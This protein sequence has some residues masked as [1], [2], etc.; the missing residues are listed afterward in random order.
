MCPCALVCSLARS[1]SCYLIRSFGLLGRERA[2]SQHR[3]RSYVHCSCINSVLNSM[4]EIVKRKKTKFKP[5]NPYLV[6]FLAA[7]AAAALDVFISSSLF[8]RYFV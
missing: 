1:P 4:H 3:N 8:V 6:F 7:A 5:S 2:R